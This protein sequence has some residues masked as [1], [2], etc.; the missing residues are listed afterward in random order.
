MISRVSTLFQGHKDL[1]VGFNT[2]LPMGY[3]IELNK[4]TDTISIIH[5]KVIITLFV[6]FKQILTFVS[7]ITKVFAFGSIRRQQE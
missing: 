5:P 6:Q 2:F 4:A 3:K 1:I 7:G